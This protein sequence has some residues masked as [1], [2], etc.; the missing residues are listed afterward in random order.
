MLTGRKDEFALFQHLISL[1]CAAAA[2]AARADQL[3]RMMQ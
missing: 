1:R 2:A 3:P